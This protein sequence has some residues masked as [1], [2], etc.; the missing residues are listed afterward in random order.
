MHTMKTKGE[1][2]HGKELLQELMLLSNVDLPD[3]LRDKVQQQALLCL[4]ILS[5]KMYVYP[6]KCIPVFLMLLFEGGKAQ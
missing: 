4:E 2:Y 5:V 1:K 3:I 6:G